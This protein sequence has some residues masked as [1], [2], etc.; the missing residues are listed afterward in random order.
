MMDVMEAILTRR[1]IRKYKPK[2]IPRE[3]ILKLLEAANLAPTAGNKQPWEFIVVE[4]N[5]LNKMENILER[6]FF[7]RVE[8]MSEHA[9]EEYIKNLPIPTDTFEDKM[10]GLGHFFKSLGDA[11][12]AVMVIIPKDRNPWNWINN[13]SDASA[14]IE[15]LILAA[16]NMGLGTCWMTAP[17]RKK[18]EEIKTFLGVEP[19][20]EIIAVVPIGI[21]DQDP[22][23][24]P[25]IDVREKIKWV[26]ILE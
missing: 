23:I 21:P 22:S 16:W 24:P 19:D 4:R 25:K 7:E 18:G 11:P 14:A 6:S 26:G 3:S 17:L 10:K 15:N 2:P 9:F 1:S 20:K 12:V 5:Y 13:I 8:E